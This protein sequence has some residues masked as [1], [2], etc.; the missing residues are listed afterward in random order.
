MSLLSP[1]TL[2]RL[3]LPLPFL[4]IAS[5]AVDRRPPAAQLTISLRM[6]ITSAHLVEVCTHG[7]L[8]V[9]LSAPAREHDNDIRTSLTAA[10]PFDGSGGG[11]SAL[12]LFLRLQAGREPSACR[13]LRR[14]SLV[15]PVRLTLL[16][17]RRSLCT[18]S[19]ANAHPTA[20]IQVLSAVPSSPC[21]A[22]P[23]LLS[24]DDLPATLPPA[25]SLL[26]A[27]R[28]PPPA[29]QEL[30]LSVRWA[31]L[32]SLETLTADLP[33]CLPRL[34]DAPSA[35]YRASVSAPPAV[36]VANS[37]SVSVSVTNDGACAADLVLCA[38][39]KPAPDA[40]QLLCLSAVTP[41]GFVLPKATTTA[42]LQLYALTRGP[43]A[44]RLQLYVQDL[45]TGDGAHL[46]HEQCYVEIF[47]Q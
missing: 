30:L 26:L 16:S 37:F 32:G 3:A 9:H 8:H 1:R 31:P 47:V 6:H 2:P 10:D 17:A 4:P 7:C 12:P 24:H 27:C 5:A 20:S 43:I 11:G 13:V 19:L 23:S 18:L 46:P 44:T 35:P 14:L 29:H 33:V 39:T 38:D 15:Q 36:I 40:P 25:A 42:T 21:A 28:L 22:Q 45:D 34:A 41:L